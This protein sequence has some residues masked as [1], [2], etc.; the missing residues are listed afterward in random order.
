MKKLDLKNVLA[1]LA[2]MSIMCVAST[3]SAYGQESTDSVKTFPVKV[4][5]VDDG[6][7]I[8]NTVIYLAYYDDAKAKLVE[9]S[10]NTGDGNVVSFD[11]PFDQKTAGA[12]YSFVVLISKDEIDEVKKAAGS[13]RV[14]MFR[15]PPGESCEYLELVYNK[16]G[17]IGNKGCSIQMQYK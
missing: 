5:Y 8:P 17:G 11:I 4:K 7:I 9:K 3:L 14:R 15:V 12:T 10:A 16:S 1:S 6:K 2:V 13:G